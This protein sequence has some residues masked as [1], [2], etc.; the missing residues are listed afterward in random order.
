VGIEFCRPNETHEWV[1]QKQ[2]KSNSYPLLHQM[3]GSKGTTYKYN[4][5]GNKIHPQIH[6][7]MIWVF[8]YFGK[9]LEHSFY[10]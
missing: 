8:A 6:F 1:Y 2:I 5:H 7:H 9:W 4:G 10:Q 3:G